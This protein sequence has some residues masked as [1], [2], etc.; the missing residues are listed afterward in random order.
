MPAK[1]FEMFYF[2]SCRSRFL[3]LI[4]II[5]NIS[6]CDFSFTEFPYPVEVTQTERGHPRI[7]YNGYAYG[8]YNTSSIY[9][10]KRHTW[11]C[12]RNSAQTGPR[13]RC[14]ASIKS[15]Y[16]NGSMNIGTE[17]TNHN[18]LQSMNDDPY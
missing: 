3:Q 7:H 4:I 10:R 5:D 13:K 15:L 12:T 11:F 16:F 9:T 17:P 18:C 14:R 2:F 8:L 1:K 6:L